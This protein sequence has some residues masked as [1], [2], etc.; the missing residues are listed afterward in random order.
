MFKAFLGVVAIARPAMKAVAKMPLEDRS[1][2]FHEY[3]YEA[4]NLQTKEYTKANRFP[5]NQ[6]LIKKYLPIAKDVFDQT[7][8]QLKE[9]NALRY[10]TPSN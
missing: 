8:F 4:Q 2:V 1:D 6:P 10:A 7:Y 3:V 5:D 9:N